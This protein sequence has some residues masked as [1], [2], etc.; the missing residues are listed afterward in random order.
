MNLVRAQSSQFWFLLMFSI[1][2][3]AKL[4]NLSRSW[5]KPWVLCW[6]WEVT[7]C[8]YLPWTECLDLF[9]I[10][11][12]NRDRGICG[13]THYSIRA[14]CGFNCSNKQGVAK[15]PLAHYAL[16]LSNPPL[17]LGC[18]YPL[19]WGTK[20]SLLSRGSR[21]F[22]HPLPIHPQQMWGWHGS[23]GCMLGL[24]LRAR[25]PAHSNA[26][27]CESQLSWAASIV[28]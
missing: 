19:S 1:R 18:S 17:I 21:W 26:A 9:F 2:F 8:K 3:C 14:V 4:R 25:A 12:L 23:S 16:H 10:Y 7:V 22:R 13:W 5:S 6:R 27:Q 28:R 20:L 11:L 15:S 24:T